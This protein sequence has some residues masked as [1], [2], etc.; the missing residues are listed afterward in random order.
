MR[1]QGL[2]R[3]M[4]YWFLCN[5]LLN[6]HGLSYEG[7]LQGFSLWTRQTTRG[8]WTA[9]SE[10]VIS[11]NFVHS[12]MST[13]NMGAISSS[14]IEDIRELLEVPSSQTSNLIMKNKAL[15]RR[16]KI[17]VSHIAQTQSKILLCIIW[18]LSINYMCKINKRHKITITINSSLK[19]CWTHIQMNGWVSIVNINNGANELINR[20][21]NYNI[22]KYW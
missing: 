3:A 19:Q 21:W 11:Y 5:M 14:W 6:A 13:T 9:I 4:A 12:W 7:Q 2:W 22:A 15:P 1:V 17:R 8:E 16:L 18:T 10:V 20:Y